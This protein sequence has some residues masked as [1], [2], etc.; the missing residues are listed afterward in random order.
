MSKKLRTRRHRVVLNRSA[1]G[2]FGINLMLFI[3]GAIMFL[4]LY[5]VVIQ[6]LKPL[7]ELFYYPP[8]FYV[9]N[10]TFQN[11]TDLFQLM[12]E[13]WVP[14]SRY[15]FNTVWITFA[16]T[17][18]NL[19]LSSLCAYALSKIPFPGHGFFFQ[20]IVKSL[21]I[22]SAVAGT[23]QFV[24]L[25]KMGLMDSQWAIILPTWA[26]TLGLYLMKQFIDANISTE[27]LESARLDGAGEFRTF[28]SIAM[29][30]VKP[31]WLTLIVQ[32]FQGL[33]NTGASIFIQS[34][35]LKTLNYAM[36]QVLSAGIVRQGAV[37]AST[38]IM[39]IVPVIV[40]VVS[41]SNIIETMA[42][43]GMKD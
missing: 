36:S 19:I 3:L 22:S 20:L 35:E 15:I 38:V 26:S 43:S 34:E 31:A 5:Y 17:A 24:I 4:P 11:F 28:W 40:F 25:T 7:D 6:S 10:P 18:G 2:D 32:S 14:F 1:G 41:Q 9:I 13:S 21:M 23:L 27:M 30:L 37:S 12:S 29:P 8:K 33:W 39:L 42:T 16:G